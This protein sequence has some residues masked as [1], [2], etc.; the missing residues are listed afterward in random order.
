MATRMGG[1]PAAALSENG[2]AKA[3]N[4]ARKKHDG[5]NTLFIRSHPAQHYTPAQSGAIRRIEPCIMLPEA[6]P[7][8][9]LRCNPTQEQ[10]RGGFKWDRRRGGDTCG[11]FMDALARPKARPREGCW[12]NSV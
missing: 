2:R 12:M 3:Q 6:R 11:E 7:S 10:E 4:A 1:S 9:H 5:W 8:S